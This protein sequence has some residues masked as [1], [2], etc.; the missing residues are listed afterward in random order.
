MILR[1]ILSLKV[2]KLLLMSQLMNHCIVFNDRYYVFLLFN[3]K[4]KNY[5]IDFDTFKLKMDRKIIIATIKMFFM[6]LFFILLRGQRMVSK[7]LVN[8][9]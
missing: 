5:C 8:G 3:A 4:K 7:W 2:L 1:Y 9:Q 6:L